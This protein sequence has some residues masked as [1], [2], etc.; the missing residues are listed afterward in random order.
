M[1]SIN[2]IQRISNCLTI[3]YRIRRSFS[4]N[5]RPLH[6]NITWKNNKNGS[7][8]QRISASFRDKL[9]EC[10]ALL[11]KEFIEASQR[12]SHQQELAFNTD[13]FVDVNRFTPKKQIQ[14]TT[15]K[16]QS[17]S[18]TATVMRYEIRQVGWHLVLTPDILTTEDDG[19][20]IDEFAQSPRIQNMIIKSNSF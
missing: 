12:V 13:G 19:A 14:H 15:V 4:Q 18:M 5:K 6:G 16:K 9:E 17:L 11:A 3:L 7:T 1:H 8:K 10:P 20:G 2:I